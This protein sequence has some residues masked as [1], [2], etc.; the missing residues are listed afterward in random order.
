V[1]RFISVLIFTGV[2]LLVGCSGYI[3]QKAA[4]STPYPSNS[5][6]KTNAPKTPDISEETAAKIFNIGDIVRLND[7]TYT[8]N[9][10]RE[11]PE[12][13]FLSPENGNIWYA[14]D[15]TIENKSHETF[16]FNSMLMFTLFD[17]ENLSYDTAIVPDLK[18]NV[19]G[20]IAP[21]SSLRGEVAFEIPQDAK[22]L[23]LEIDPI[24]FGEKAIIKLDR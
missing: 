22:D 8:V 4:E 20:E 5:I 18:G 24:L 3:P 19:D 7:I 13:R 23:K 14:I 2:L 10:I 17:G 21:E 15:I 11:V 1:K 12:N 9:S 16:N 6:T